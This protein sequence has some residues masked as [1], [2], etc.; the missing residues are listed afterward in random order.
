MCYQIAPRVFAPESRTFSGTW[1]ASA[2]RYIGDR[3]LNGERLL[4][5]LMGSGA[6]V[7]LVD[8]LLRRLVLPLVLIACKTKFNDFGLPRDYCNCV[9]CIKVWDIQ[10]VYVRREIYISCGRVCLACR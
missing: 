8:S 4:V 10:S 9:T 3:A 6:A 7:V 1:T 5:C 2:S